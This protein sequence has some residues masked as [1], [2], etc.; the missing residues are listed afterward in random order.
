MLSYVLVQRL[1]YLSFIYHTCDVDPVVDI[2]IVS[3]ARPD[4]RLLV[5]FCITTIKM[6]LIYPR[7]L[8]SLKT[9]VCSQKC[10]LSILVVVA[11]LY[12]L[13]ILHRNNLLELCSVVITHV[14][15]IQ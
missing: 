1:K 11:S 6:L 15:N 9:G 14:Y 8:P 7:L 2:R 5:T 4:K 13:Y 3:V 10:C 12:E